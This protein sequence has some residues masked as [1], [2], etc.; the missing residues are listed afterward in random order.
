MA[1]LTPEQ[2]QALIVTEL[3]SLQLVATN[4]ATY[5]ELATDAASDGE[6]YLLAKRAALDLVLG[7]AANQVSFRALDG[8]SVNLSDRFDHLVQLRALV[9]GV[10]DA[11]AGAAQGGGA[12]G[13][14]TTTAPIIAP[15]GSLDANAQVYRGSP[16]NRR[17][18][19]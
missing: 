11:G 7:Q 10:I 3:G 15:A 6:R 9:Q 12:L 8:S 14:M 19:R 5:W 16:Y 18:P 4:I 17:W 13:E 2:W 1:E